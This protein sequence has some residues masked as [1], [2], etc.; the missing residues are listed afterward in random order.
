MSEE[1]K[2]KYKCYYCD[3]VFDKQRGMLQHI[4]YS[5]E[6]KLMSPQAENTTT[7]HEKPEVQEPAPQ[8]SRFRPSISRN[9]RESMMEIMELEMM[10]AWIDRMKAES[11][12]PSEFM[13]LLDKQQAEIKE[14]LDALRDEIPDPED[15]RS[16]NVEG[17]DF[18]LKD[19]KELIET[20][21]QEAPQNVGVQRN[22]EIPKTVQAQLKLLKSLP[23]EQQVAEIMIRAP[24]LN[25]TKAKLVAQVLT[26]D[27]ILSALKN[28]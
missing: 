22:M 24:N 25:K 8:Q 15:F 10:Q 16:V 5:H 27:E 14:Q 17:Q 1:E 11:R 3:A 20:F 19:I 18:N 6:D 26:D 23:P 4:V 2:P 7:Y 9:M 12:Q 13:T 28:L 21:K